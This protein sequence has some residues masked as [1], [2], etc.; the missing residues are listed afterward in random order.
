MNQSCLFCLEAVE[1][2]GQENP[3]GCH[4]KII[5]HTGCFKQ[6]F[7]QKQQMECP[8]CHSVSVPNRITLDNIHVVYINMAEPRRNRLMNGHEKAVGFCCCLLM[9]WAVGLTILDLI[10][11][12]H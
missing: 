3:I 7:E 5:A 11:Q 9:G 4:C 1:K 8:I 12:N 6:W 2:E 10:F